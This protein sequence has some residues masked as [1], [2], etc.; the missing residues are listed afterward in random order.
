ME[1]GWRVLLLDGFCRL[2]VTG[3]EM[4]RQLTP[5]DDRKLGFGRDLS[6]TLSLLKFI[7]GLEADESSSIGLIQA[8]VSTDMRPCRR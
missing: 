2:C 6:S 4:L 7:F 5:F 8:R 3:D 1:L